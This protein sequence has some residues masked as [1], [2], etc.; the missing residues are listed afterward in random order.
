MAELTTIHRSPALP[1]IKRNR[2]TAVLTAFGSVGII[3]AAAAAAKVNSGISTLELPYTPIPASKGPNA[4]LENPALLGPQYPDVNPYNDSYP[5]SSP[6]G[7]F[8]STPANNGAVKTLEEPDDVLKPARLTYPFEFGRQKTTVR[9]HPTATKYDDLA[10]EIDPNTDISDLVLIRV[11]GEYYP[12]APAGNVTINH[13]GKI[14]KGGAWYMFARLLPLDP[15]GMASRL[16]AVDPKTKQPIKKGELPHVI[17]RTMFQPET[18]TPTP[19]SKPSSPA[20][21]K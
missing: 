12:G 13:E 21:Q 15:R 9:R 17:A 1:S 2:R 20:S 16:V 11:S 18:P 19:A 10:Y 8:I 7:K 14:T 6:F 5:K 3:V 4:T